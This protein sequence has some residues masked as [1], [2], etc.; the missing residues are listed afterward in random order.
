MKKYI[1]TMMVIALSMQTYAQVVVGG[2]D[3][4]MSADASAP[5][6]IN[7][8]NLVGLRKDTTV[9]QGKGI[10]YPRVN[11]TRVQDFGVSLPTMPNPLTSVSP[12]STFLD[13]LVVYNTG[14]G[15]PAPGANIGSVEGGSFTPGFW[16]YDNRN[17]Q[18]TSNAA[19]LV[20]GTWRPLGSGGGST[21]TKPSGSWIYCPPFM[22]DLEETSVNLFDEYKR[23]LSLGGFTVSSPGATGVANL[24]E[25]AGDF[26]YL[27]RYEG[28]SITITSVSSTGVMEYEVIGT[29]QPDEF[30]S[31]VLVR[32]K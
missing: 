13:G 18:A 4:V 8:N 25:N 6:F 11:L 22:L 5:A 16:Y 20:A 31:V 14:T 29:P 23:G 32:N 28:S 1:L 19:R 12:Y 10:A 2:T 15:S 17:P 21:T 3:I 30:I 26:D 9:L 7:A 24:V 27:V